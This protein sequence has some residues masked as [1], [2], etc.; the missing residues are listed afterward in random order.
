MNNFYSIAPV[1][2]SIAIVV[3]NIALS[4]VLQLGIAWIYKK[5]HRGLSYAPSFVFTLIII[6]T[7]GTFVMM[8]IQQ[9]FV[10]AVAL[11]GAFSLIRFRTILKE[12]RDVAFVFFALAAG[13]AIGTG[14]YATGLVS[15]VLISLIIL[16]LDWYK[17]GSITKST[18]FILTF[19]ANENFD[20]NAAKSVLARNS[21]TFNLLQTRT[22]GVGI[23][24][25]VFS[26]KL[27]DALQ[28]TEIVKTLKR[29]PSILDVELITGEHSVEY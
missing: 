6:G 26:L 21:N 9:N 18:G 29:D 23:E 11:L 15:V 14:N 8:I 19:N 13:V 4:F 10:G 28:V 3:L 27:K 25:Y 20:I 1:E 2:L 5:T 17:I 22:H 24:T 12:T 16:A 7:L